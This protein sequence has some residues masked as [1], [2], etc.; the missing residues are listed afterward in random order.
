MKVDRMIAV[1]TAML[2]RAESAQELARLTSLLVSLQAER[3]AELEKQV[4]K[5][6]RKVA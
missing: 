5:L 1:V 6:K 3:I 2:V 4:V